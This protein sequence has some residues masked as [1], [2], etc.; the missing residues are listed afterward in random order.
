MKTQ[1]SEDQVALIAQ[2]IGLAEEGPFAPA[3]ASYTHRLQ[4]LVEDLWGMMTVTD[5]AA[6]TGLR[7]WHS[8]T[9]VI[10]QTG[11]R[12]IGTVCNWRN[13]PPLRLTSGLLHF[14][15]TNNSCRTASTNRMHPS[16]YKVRT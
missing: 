15:Q 8:G 7:H 6:V 12:P 14:G 16:P 2:A 1:E 4:G 10:S 5:L 11:L 13:R 9:S 3:Y